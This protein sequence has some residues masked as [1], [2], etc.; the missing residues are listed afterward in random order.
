MIT[1]LMLTKEIKHEPCYPA[2]RSNY[3]FARNRTGKHIQTNVTNPPRAECS[4]CW[5]NTQDLQ[6]VTAKNKIKNK[7]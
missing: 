6:G 3:Q 4:N 2:S 1:L 5:T 7:K